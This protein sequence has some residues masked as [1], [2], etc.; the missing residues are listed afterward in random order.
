MSKSGD[1]I[2][3]YEETKDFEKSYKLAG[4]AD[5]EILYELTYNVIL[6]KKLVEL[7]ETITFE[8]IERLVNGD[9]S[10]QDSFWKKTS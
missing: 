7:S 3:H 6:R 1:L 5:A 8:N 4:Y 9:K 2:R 10:N